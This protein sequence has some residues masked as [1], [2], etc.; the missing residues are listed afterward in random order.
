MPRARKKFSVEGK[1]I[2]VECKPTWWGKGYGGQPKVKG[3]GY[4]SW[5][6]SQCYG[7]YKEEK[8]ALNRAMEEVVSDQLVEEI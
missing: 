7:P 1:D 6:G 5:L 2:V 3:L 4:Y 8:N